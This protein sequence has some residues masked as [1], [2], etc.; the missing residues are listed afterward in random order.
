MT[1]SIKDY[2]IQ[3]IIFDMDGTMVDNMMVHHQAWQ[4]KLSS[5]GLKMSLAEVMEKVHGVNEEILEGLFGD[6]F[7]PAERKQIAWEKEAE[8]RKIFKPELQLVE[9]LPSL[10]DQL[11][12]IDFPFGVGTAAPAENADFI[13]DELDIRSYF[14]TI[15]HAGQVSNGKPHPEVFEKA[16]A[17]MGIAPEHCLVFEDSPTGIHT[18]QNAGCLAV[19]V[20]TTHRK[21]E[22]E[23]FDNVLGYVKNFSEVGLKKEGKNWRMSL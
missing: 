13:L 7:T 17:G 4:R 14:K 5:L 20:L 18:A 16:A 6:R 23:G 8:Y 10:L 12:S 1:I 22:F 15:V 3:G 11:K 19:A 21:E 9:G 2:P